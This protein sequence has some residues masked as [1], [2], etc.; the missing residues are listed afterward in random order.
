MTSVSQ[1]NDRELLYLAEERREI[2]TFAAS[3]FFLIL[4]KRGNVYQINFFSFSLCQFVIA[5]LFIELCSLSVF[6]SSEIFFYFLSWPFSSYFFIFKEILS[7]TN[8]LRSFYNFVSNFYHFIIFS[9]VFLDF[10][11]LVFLVSFPSFLLVS[12]F[13]FFHFYLQKMR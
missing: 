4:S 2:N 13:I 11:F 10:Y 3:V 6:F 7:W 12:C 5:F 1:V 9:C 8:L